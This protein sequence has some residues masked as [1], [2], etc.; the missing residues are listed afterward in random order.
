[1][2]SAGSYVRTAG[3]LYDTG[4]RTIELERPS[5]GPQIFCMSIT[6][7]EPLLDYESHDRSILGHNVRF[8]FQIPSQVARNALEQVY[9][10][11]SW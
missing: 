7:A 1:M 5:L 3:S 4:K 10:V 8:I 6:P 9:P 11:S 2:S